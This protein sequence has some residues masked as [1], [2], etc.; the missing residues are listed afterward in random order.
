MPKKTDSKQDTQEKQE[1]KKEWIPIYRKQLHDAI[2]YAKGDLS[3][4]EFAKRCG[5]NPMTLS[6]AINNNIEKP[7]KEETIRIMA[8]KSDRRTED[9]LEYLMRANGYVK[10]D[11]EERRQEFEQ[12]IQE[13]NNC[14]EKIQSVIMGT[15]FDNGYTIMPIFNTP[16]ESTDPMLKESKHYLRTRVRFALRVR[17]LEP[18]GFEPDFWNFTYQFFSADESSGK[19]ENYERE[20]N[21]QTRRMIDMTK[22]IFLR[23]MWEPEVFDKSLYSI[24]F[25]NKDLFESYYKVFEDVSLNGSVSLILIDLDDQQVVEERFLSRRDGRKDESLQKILSSILSD[26]SL[27]RSKQQNNQ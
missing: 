12:F 19:K 4:A 20:I 11:D 27:F 16:L 14:R 18:K 21:R 26:E 1:P 23:D 7:L 13:R 24:V 15:L 22:D 8:D 25:T 10:N 5:L 3:M 9:V 2:M 6:R 17:S